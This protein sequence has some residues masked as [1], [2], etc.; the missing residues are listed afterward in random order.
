MGAD[1]ARRVEAAGNFDFFW[2]VLEAGMPGLMLR[3][4]ASPDP[5]P[6][7][8]KLKNLVASFRPTVGGWAFVLGLKERAQVE[9]FETLCRDVVNAGEGGKDRED[10]L[11]AQFSA[12]GAGTTFCGA[13][14]RV[15]FQ[16]KSSGVL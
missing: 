5:L 15:D 8:P 4:P 13:G 9:I 1:D 16:W 12:P 10:A 2:V 3:L 11:S 7:L 14:G 6:K